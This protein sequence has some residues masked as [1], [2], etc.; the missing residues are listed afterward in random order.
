MDR[1][2]MTPEE[3]DTKRVV[4]TLYDAYFRGDAAGM[5]ELMADDVWIRFLGREDFRGKGRAAEFFSQNNPMLENLNF[6][7]DKLVIDGSHAAAVWSE[8]A[9]TIHGEDYSNHGVDVFEVRDGQIISVH[10]NNDITIHRA[11]FGRDGT[12]ER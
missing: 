7:I 10:E 11:H 3:R 4:D 12:S 8:T 1:E 6:E 5:V 2:D 9:R